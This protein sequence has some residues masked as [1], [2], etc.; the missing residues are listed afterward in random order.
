VPNESEGQ[1]NESDLTRRGA[2][3]DRQADVLRRFGRTMVEE[4]SMIEGG[5]VAAVRRCGHGDAEIVEV[6]ARVGLDVFA[7][8]FNSVAGTAIDF[9]EAPA[10]C[11]CVSPATAEIQGGPRMPPTWPGTPP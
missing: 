4:R 9:P 1:P 7:N 2:C 5:G 6:V 3:A 8:Y 11:A 10:R